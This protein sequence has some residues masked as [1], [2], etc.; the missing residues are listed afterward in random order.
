MERDVTIDFA[1]IVERQYIHWIDQI[2]PLLLRF[3]EL[4][5]SDNRRQAL[6]LAREVERRMN[7][8]FS[9]FR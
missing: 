7:D 6:S 8:T 3:N 5:E 2:W 9:W 4:F 1:K